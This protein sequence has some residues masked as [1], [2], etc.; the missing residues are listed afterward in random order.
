MYD[1]I[2][3]GAGPA[4]LTAAVYAARKK[5]KTLVLTKDVGGQTIW[6][7]GIENYLGFRMIPGIEL[8][9]KFEEHIKEFDVEL[10]TN[11]GV[12]GIMKKDNYFEIFTKDNEYSGKAVIIASGK[13]PRKLNVPGEDEFLGKGVAYC[14]TCDAPLFAGKDVAVIGSG[15]SA[16]DAAFQLSQIGKK[17]YIININSGLGGDEITQDKVKSADN[18]EIINNAK[19]LEINGDVFVNNIKIKDTIK[20]IEKIISVQ[21]VFVEIGS[22]PSSDFAKGLLEMNDLKEIKI[23][24]KGETSAAGIF[25]A[26]DVTNIP[27]KQIISAAGDGCKAA[28]SAY[29]YL[30]KT[31]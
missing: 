25:A 2:I 30:I 11:K 1:L 4:G 31:R 24:C 16:L 22:V 12:T 28:L 7:F 5:L 19:T 27:A 18:I 6:S 15:N 10:K 9:R 20:G 17:I 3:I 29:D 13:I 23:N 14:A 8:V 26:G 21:G